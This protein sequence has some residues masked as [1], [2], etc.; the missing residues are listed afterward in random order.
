MKD[1]RIIENVSQ[2]YFSIARFYGGCT[3]SGKNFK[4]FPELDVLIRSDLV[5]KFKKAMKH[6]I[7]LKEFAKEIKE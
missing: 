2:S 6:G 1:I 7:S 4:Y 5:G 3:I